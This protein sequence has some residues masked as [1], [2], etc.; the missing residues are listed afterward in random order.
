MVPLQQSR[1]R[2]RRGDRAGRMT[3]RAFRLPDD[4]PRM[5]ALG[6]ARRA[7]WTAQALDRRLS[8]LAACIEADVVPDAKGQRAGKDGRKGWRAVPVPPQLRGHMAD[9]ATAAQRCRIFI[10]EGD[11]QGAGECL[12]GIEALVRWMNEQIGITGELGR[13]KRAEGGRSRALRPD[14]KI[15]GS[16]DTVADVVSEVDALREKNPRL[17]VT[18]ARKIVAK[19]R[20]LTFAKVRRRHDKFGRRA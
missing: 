9:L 5:Q 3:V 15:S 20:N 7:P 1:R 14:D 17:S 2:Q 19:N 13:E 12:G 4:L 18:Q 11:I 8:Y 16:D 6:Y 10:E